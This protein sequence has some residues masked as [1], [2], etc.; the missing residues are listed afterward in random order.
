[1]YKNK[2]SAVYQIVNTVTGDR[3]VGSSKNV[4]Q[5]WVDHKK[6]SK[7]KSHPNIPLYQG[8]QKY[9]LENF[10]FQILAPVMPEYLKQVEQEFIDL[11]HPTYN[12]CN[13][14]GQNTERQ[15]ETLKEYN[16]SERR[17]E[18]YRRYRQSDKSKARYKRHNSR[19]CFYNSETLK[20][21]ALVAR[22]IKAGV[23]HPS[24]EAR[25]Y[26]IKGEE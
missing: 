4:F 13:A 25:K 2:I 20:F 7:W 22:F 12:C 26:L 9:G 5:R 24:V 14:N 21:G 11:L 8:M 10:R 1:M 16:Q 23:E 15:K 17:K 6:P 3:Y 19:L 18:S